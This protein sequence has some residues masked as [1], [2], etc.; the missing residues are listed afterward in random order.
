MRREKPLGV[1]YD[2]GTAKEPRMR[3]ENETNRRREQ[4]V[5]KGFSS[6]HV[7]VPEHFP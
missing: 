2:T 5:K 1:S 7:R 4:P 3:K 6:L